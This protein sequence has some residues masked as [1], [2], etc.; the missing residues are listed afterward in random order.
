[1]GRYSSMIFNENANS[2]PIDI[3][4]EAIQR[5]FADVQGIEFHYEPTMEGTEAINAFTEEEYFDICES[6][7]LKELEYFSINRV[8]MPVNEAFGDGGFLEKVKNFFISIGKKIKVL[9]DKFIMM[10]NRFVMNDKAFVKK[11]GDKI[12]SASTVGVEYK[13]FN[14]SISEN[15][16][17]KAESKLSKY[18]TR[19]DSEILSSHKDTK[20]EEISAKIR[21]AA[22]GQSELSSSEYSKELFKLFRKG[23]DSK[24]NVTINAD[25]I[26]SEI[27]SAKQDKTDAMKAYKSVKT[28][29]NKLISIVDGRKKSL[30]KETGSVENG[31]AQRACTYDVEDLKTCLSAIQTYNGAYLTAIKARNRQNKGVALRLITKTAKEGYEMPNDL[32][33]V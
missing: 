11:Y 28:F 29:I 33:F 10:I 2:G 8:E 21:G 18:F 5:E 27:T 22:L 19:S 24:V 25:N 3:S 23:E 17:D 13:G 14:F 1:M 9:F 32:S 26:V 15:G 30:G 4:D 16:I 31:D 12:K 6:C 7:G 20:S